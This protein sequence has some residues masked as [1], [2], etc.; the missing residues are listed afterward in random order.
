MSR[1]IWELKDDG[2]EYDIS[3]KIMEREQPFSPVTGVCA[4]CTTEKWYILFKPELA[5]INKRDKINNHGFH[6]V[7]VLLDNT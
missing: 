5:T 4:L 1:K 3:W 7:P 2:Y 6:K